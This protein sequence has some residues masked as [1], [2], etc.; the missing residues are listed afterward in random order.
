M[1]QFFMR[2]YC[3]RAMARKGDPGSPIRFVASTEDVA[4]DGLIIKADGWSLGSFRRNPVA[5]WSHDYLGKNLPIGRTD[6][7]V[8]N[9]RLMADITFDQGDPFAVQIERKYRDGFLHA[10][11]VGWQTLE[12]E[13]SSDP[14]VRGIVT[15]A[16]L[17]DLSCV[18]VPGDAKALAERQIRGL[19]DLLNEQGS[20]ARNPRGRFL[21][22]FKSNADELKRLLTSLQMQMRYR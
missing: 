18:P 11:S 17:L 12:M 20:D 3:D 10:V 22:D 5:L 1:E 19:R 8:V 4:R 16:E 6:V 2:G 14:K 7:E 21:E 15:K 13:S 9:R